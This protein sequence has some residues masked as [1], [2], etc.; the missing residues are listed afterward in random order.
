M[1]DASNCLPSCYGTKPRRAP[2][3]GSL[4]RARVW[5]QPSRYARLVEPKVAELCHAPRSVC[6][7]SARTLSDAYT[8]RWPSGRCAIDGDTKLSAFTLLTA[9]ASCWASILPPSV[10]QTP[11]KCCGHR[12][13][14]CKDAG[15]LDTEV[16]DRLFR[17]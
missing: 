13:G 3:K 15:R 14:R 1:A 4:S 2:V 12:G 9:R 17:S 11:S 6:L 8:I 16:S 7:A 5:S 10:S